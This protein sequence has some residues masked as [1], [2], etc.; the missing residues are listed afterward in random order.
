M[1]SYLYFI[2]SDKV[3]FQLSLVKEDIQ[4]QIQDLLENGQNTAKG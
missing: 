1:T 3:S 4:P 2:V